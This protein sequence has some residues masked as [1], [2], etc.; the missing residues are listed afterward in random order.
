MKP[1][2]SHKTIGTVV[3][4]VEHEKDFQKY[5]KY[6]SHPW[7]IIWRNFLAGTFHG[8]GFIL[9]TALL[10]T[11]LGYIVN[12]VMGELPFFSDFAQAINVWLQTTLEK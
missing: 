5:V 12:S 10:L 2:L 4:K 7:H 1:P 3:F 8:V 9:G 11:I 6:L